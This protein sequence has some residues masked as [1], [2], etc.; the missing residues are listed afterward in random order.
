MKGKLNS[1]YEALALPYAGNCIFHVTDIKLSFQTNALKHQF[2][3]FLAPGAGF[4][5][6][7]SSMEEGAMVSGWFKCITVLCTPLLLHQLP[8]RS[9]GIRSQSLGGPALKEEWFCS[10][11]DEAVQV[12]GH[13]GPQDGIGAQVCGCLSPCLYNWVGLPKWWEPRK[14]SFSGLC[15]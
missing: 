4:V 15:L 6:D 1:V 3:I 14:F 8:L 7:N 10:L 13:R 2:P 5:E 9:S 12:Q 11:D